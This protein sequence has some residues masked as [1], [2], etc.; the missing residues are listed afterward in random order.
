VRSADGASDVDGD[1]LPDGA[2]RCPCVA[3][4]QQ[5]DTDGDGLGN[6]CDADDDG[7]GTPDAADCAPLDPGVASLP[8]GVGATVRPGTSSDELVWEPGAATFAW[9]V[10]R[11][12]VDAG[13]PFAF[14]HLCHERHSPDPATTDSGVPQNGAWFYYLVSAWNS[15]GESDL[16]SASDGTVRPKGPACP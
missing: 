12:T 7:D 3:D 6:A 15:C 1:G 4:P 9:N 2:D 10:Y 11:G 16:G 8:S 13:A 14:G 5:T